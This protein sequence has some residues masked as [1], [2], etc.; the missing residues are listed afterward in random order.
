MSADDEDRKSLEGGNAVPADSGIASPA[1]SQGGL[2]AGG[3]HNPR[4]GKPVPVDE[5]KTPLGLSPFASSPS[6]SIDDGDEQDQ[7][8]VGP[9]PDAVLMM[10][11]EI[12]AQEEKRASLV[13]A[14]GGD[15]VDDSALPSPQALALGVARL[16]VARGHASAEELADLILAA[17]A[18]LA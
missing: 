1:T 16:Q 17:E 5:E 2:A 8:S 3:G 15:A 7:T 11:A 18:D 10:G 14:L 6:A 9:M 13:R 4:A 12:L